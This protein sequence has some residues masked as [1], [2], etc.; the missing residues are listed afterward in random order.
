MLELI[1]FSKEVEIKFWEYLLHHYVAC[2]LIF[3]SLTLNIRN[4]K[5]HRLVKA[6]MMVLVVHDISD[7]LLSIGRSYNDMKTSNKYLVYLQY[8]VLQVSWIYTRLWV[9]PTC[10]IAENSKAQFEPQLWY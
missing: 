5:I 7:I 9:F 10:I 2:A 6:G 1:I 4:P 3:F 8:V